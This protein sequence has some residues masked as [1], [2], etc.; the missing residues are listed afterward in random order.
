MTDQEL[1][2]YCIMWAHW[3]RTR[4][5][6][7]PPVPPNILAQLQPRR[8]SLTE[9]DGPMSA[10]LSFFNAAIHGLADTDKEDA[11]CFL[12]Y[13]Y[14]GFRPVKAIASALGIGRQTLYDRINRFARRALK[15]A[16]TIKRVHLEHSAEQKCTEK[17]V[18]FN[19]VH[20]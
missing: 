10:D 13:H 1:T 7:A 2:A 6:F 8:V 5:Y 9:P 19:P 17:S 14:H 16:A 18:Q 20:F 4:K 3:C 11:V 15:V 12:L